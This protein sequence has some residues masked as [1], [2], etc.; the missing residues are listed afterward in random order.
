MKSPYRLIVVLIVLFSV[1]IL[2]S[3][4]SSSLTT[5]LTTNTRCDGN[6][7]DVIATSDLTIDSFDVNIFNNTTTVSVY[8]K[9]GT[10]VG[11]ETTPGDWTLLGSATVTGTLDTPTALPV[12]GLSIP[13]GQT[14]GIYIF[15]SLTRVFNY[16]NNGGSVASNADLT[17]TTNTGSC[18][19]FG[20]PTVAG[21]T[22]SGTIYYTLT[23]ASAGTTGTAGISLPA[24][25]DGRI[26]NYDTASPI[27]VY[28]H[29]VN[30]ETG[31]AIYDV[32]GVLLLL[33]SPETLANAPENPDSSILIAE[34]NGVVLYRIPGEGGGL[35][36]LN[37]PQY[38]GKTYVL[39]FPELFHS[40]GYES[41]EIEN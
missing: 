28:P 26:N 37:A 2:N 20:A 6:Y 35:W 3:A 23:P 41:Y 32:N 40:G 5:S 13:A 34:A 7:F 8:Y 27:V 22:W 11:S 1:S 39:I 14:Y 18:S 24:F 29:P 9:V 38:N 33:V 10:H 19:L 25:Y 17:I 4:Q 31:L 21:R 30:G 12:G 15:S 16:I 36:Q